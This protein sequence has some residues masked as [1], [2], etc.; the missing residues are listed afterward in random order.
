MRKTVKK[1]LL[2]VLDHVAACYTYLR[3]NFVCWKCGKSNMRTPD[4]QYSH[5]ISRAQNGRMKY[6]HKNAKTLCLVCHKYW[7]HLNPTLA[8]EWFQENYPELDAELKDMNANR[9][10]GSI[11]LQGFDDQLEWVIEQLST[12]DWQRLSKHVWVKRYGVLCKIMGN[13]EDRRSVVYK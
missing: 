1:R 9:P 7:R 10:L 6:Y 12:M 8:W 4:M 3:D 2:E 11:K 5:I 13:K